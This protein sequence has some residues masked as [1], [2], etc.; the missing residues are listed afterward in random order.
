MPYAARILVATD[1]SPLSTVALEHAIAIASLC[2]ASIHLMHVHADASQPADGDEQ[3]LGALVA[4]CHAEAIVVT[5]HMCAGQPAAAIVQEAADR[6][7]DLIVLGTHGRQ[8]L[9][10][11]MLGS[12][13]EHVVRTSACPVLTVRGA[14][15]ERVPLPA[16]GAWALP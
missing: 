7:V 15:P 13:A 8:G 12:V 11:L 5:S 1:F 9:A 2:R 6:A 14:V 3:R 4:R 16:E 10:H